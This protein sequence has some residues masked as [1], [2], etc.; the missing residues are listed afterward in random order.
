MLTGYDSGHAGIQRAA[1]PRVLDD[2]PELEALPA[3][4]QFGPIDPVDTEPAQPWRVRQIQ[5]VLESSCVAA[6][7]PRFD[8]TETPI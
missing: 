6:L 8:N 1:P 2:F 3:S 7:N 5:V 4:P